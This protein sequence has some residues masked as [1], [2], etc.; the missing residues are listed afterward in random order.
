MEQ[1]APLHVK[2][3]GA[4][5]YVGPLIFAFGFLAPLTAQLLR[6]ADAQLP[7]G[8]T[9]L[10]AGLVFAGLWGGVAQIRGRWL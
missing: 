8:W 2:I 3:I 4:I 10:V 7:F 9:P 1:S 5:F 6:L